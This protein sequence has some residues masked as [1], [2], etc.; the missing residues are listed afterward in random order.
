MSDQIIPVEELQP[1]TVAQVAEEVAAEAETAEKAPE[2]AEQPTPPIAEETPEP[3]T[4]EEAPQPEEP[5]ESAEATEAAEPEARP[6]PYAMDTMDPE[7][8]QPLLVQALGSYVMCEFLLGQEHLVRREGVLTR[9]AGSFFL[10]YEEQSRS[11]IVCNLYAAK[12]ITILADGQ[13]PQEQP[14]HPQARYNT[15]YPAIMVR[16]PGNPGSR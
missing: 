2:A 6:L 8:L 1:E 4:T 14:R 15:L 13:R 3:Q 5:A 12:F 9:V 16:R 7:D 10:L 11:T